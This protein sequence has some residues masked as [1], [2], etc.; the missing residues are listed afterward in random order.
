MFQDIRLH[1]QI[2]D[3]VEYFA[4]VAGRQISNRYFHEMG[5]KG[6]RPYV[7]FFSSSNDFRLTPEGISYHANGGSFCEYMF[8]IDLPIKDLAKK[9]VLNRL[10][11]FGAIYDK[12]SDGI[13]FTDNL[14]GEESYEK[15]FFNGNAV[16][17]YYCFVHSDLRHEPKSRQE[18]LLRLVGKYLKYT[19]KVGK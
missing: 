6:G 1:G 19:D 5:E 3:K 16:S 4:T 7:R 9:E 15:V 17:N 10:V 11:M 14:Y 8:D 2:N 13:T 12:E 18:S